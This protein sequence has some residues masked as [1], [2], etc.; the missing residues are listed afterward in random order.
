[1]FLALAAMIG[2][3][4][5]VFT[6]SEPGCFGLSLHPDGSD[7]PS[8]EGRRGWTLLVKVTVADDDLLPFTEDVTVARTHLSLC[9]YYVSRQSA[10][11]LPFPKAH[12]SSA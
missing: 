9:G 7:L 4:V 1:V 10:T 6:A 12:R 2:P 3:S 5:Y 11:I 8:P